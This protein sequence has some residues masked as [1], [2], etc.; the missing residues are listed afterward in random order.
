[1][2]DGFPF[3]FCYTCPWNIEGVEYSLLHSEPCDGIL[4]FGFCPVSEV[5]RN[6]TS[7]QVHFLTDVELGA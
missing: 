5:L 6:T 3:P 4:E 1:M 2:P 7:S